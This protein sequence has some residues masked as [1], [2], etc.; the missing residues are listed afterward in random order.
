MKFIIIF[1][2]LVTQHSR[3]YVTMDYTI[4]TLSFEETYNMTDS[5]ISKFTNLTSLQLTHNNSISDLGIKDLTN[6]TFLD[7]SYQNSITNTGIKGLIN[8]RELDLTCNTTITIDALSNLQNLT[9]IYAKYDQPIFRKIL[10]DQKY[11]L[12]MRI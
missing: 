2:T 5:D 10:A 6:L 8:L 12:H 1:I 4:D 3:I 11:R 7:L 9:D